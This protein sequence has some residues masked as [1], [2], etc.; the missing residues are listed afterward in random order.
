MLLLHF[1]EGVGHNRRDI[2][3][4]SRNMAPILLKRRYG[5]ESCGTEKPEVP[6]R[7]SALLFRD[8]E[9]DVIQFKEF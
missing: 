3:N 9:T 7:R 5:H 2:V 1:G 4:R 8:Q 6:V